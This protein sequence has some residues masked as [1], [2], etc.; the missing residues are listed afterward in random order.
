MLTKAQK[1]HKKE[2]KRREVRKLKSKPYLTQV[3]KSVLGEVRSH[4]ERVIELSK[5][6][7]LRGKLLNKFLTKKT[8]SK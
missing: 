4:P 2:L 3:L 7:S 6:S 5:E 1:K 8:R